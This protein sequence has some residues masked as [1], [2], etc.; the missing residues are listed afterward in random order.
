MRAWWTVGAVFFVACGAAADVTPVEGADRSAAE[1]AP[2]GWRVL[3]EQGRALA[4]AGESE[5]ARARFLVARL[6]P[7]ADLPEIALE[8]GLMAARLDDP[9][10]A[11]EQLGVAHRAGLG[12]ARSHY[13]AGSLAAAR[14]ERAEAIE[15]YRLAAGM[16]TESAYSAA[17]VGALALELA[18]EGEDSGAAAA[19]SDF[20]RRVRYASPE[21]RYVSPVAELLQDVRIGRLRGRVLAVE[22]RENPRAIAARFEGPSGLSLYD[23][24]AVR[25]CLSALRREG[26]ADELRGIGEA[27]LTSANVDGASDAL[28]TVILEHLLLGLSRSEDRAALLGAILRPARADARGQRLARLMLA[29]LPTALTREELELAAGV[30]PRSE[31]GLRAAARVRCALRQGS[32]EAAASAIEDALEE[33]PYDF[34]WLVGLVREIDEG[35]EDECRVKS[36]E[37]KTDGGAGGVGER[38]AARDLAHAVLGLMGGDGAAALA[39]RP[40]AMGAY[41]AAAATVR[42]YGHIARYAWRAAEADAQLAVRLAPR[43]AAVAYAQALIAAALDEADGARLALRRAMA[44]DGAQALYPLELARMT[45]RGD[46]EAGDSEREWLRRAVELAPLSEAPAEAL[47]ATLLTDVEETAEEARQLAEDV[48]ARAIRTGAAARMAIEVEHA[49]ES[50]RGARLLAYEGLHF[51]EPGVRK[52][53]ERLLELRIRQLRVDDAR[54]L[55]EEIAGRRNLSDDELRLIAEAQSMALRFDAAAAAQRILCERYPERVV[56]GARM[57]DLAVQSVQPEWT[58]REIAALRAAATNVQRVTPTVRKRREDLLRW[59]DNVEV[60]SYTYV[61]DF[62]GA[63]RLLDRL[64]ARDGA[65]RWRGARAD[66]LNLAGRKDELLRV[67]SAPLEVN[68]QDER[69]RDAFLVACRRYD[70]TD[71]AIERVRGWS[72]TATPGRRLPYHAVLTGLLCEARRGEEALAQME[73]MLKLP[74]MRGAEPDRGI[75]GLNRIRALLQLGRVGEATAVMD[76]MLNRPEVRGQAEGRMQTWRELAEIMW[77]EGQ[78]E[79]ALRYLDRWDRTEHFGEEESRVLLQLRCLVLQ[80]AGR[81]REAEYVCAAERL[82]ALTPNNIGLH[83]DLGY[84]WLVLGK[85]VDRAFDLVRGAAGV[86]PVNTAYLDSLAWGHYVCGEFG[87]ALELLRRATSLL[88]GKDAV[89]LEHRGDAAYRMGDPALAHESWGEALLAAQDEQ[90]RGGTTDATR[91]G[92]IFERIWSKIR[93]LDEGRRPAVALSI[94]EMN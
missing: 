20:E 5:A 58:R 27:W 66:A 25:D 7:D 26:A 52:T 24:R 34:E 13:L 79:L 44:A 30:L 35:G 88:S 82:L 6:F 83:N 21:Y 62:D 56:E 78:F 60:E 69:A 48:A 93:A 90:S 74:E 80:L 89:M 59:L 87:E 17:A 46:E 75:L 57:I 85:N 72:A 68:P 28:T 22:A 1:A 32:A 61:G 29:H 70:L 50:Q 15:H 3:L 39:L 36:A 9:E 41:R 77:K 38:D 94:A 53:Q 67:I 42:A 37:S 19:W 43:S 54:I 45:R 2:S 47:L 86:N 12:T 81:P 64:E 18:D 23:A 91:D 10:E 40:E 55:A 73:T 8:L 49:E 51:R 92:E 65:E 16:E 31:V 63:M 84:T 14:K 71:A 33:R 11:R 76:A 4:A